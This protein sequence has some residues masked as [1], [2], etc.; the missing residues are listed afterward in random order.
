M[1][2]AVCFSGP[3]GENYP[4]RVDLF[5]FDLPPDKIALRPAVPR[6]SARLLHVQ[7]NGALE[8]RQMTDL[9]SL[10]KPGD[11]LVFNNTKVIPAQLFGVRHRGDSVLRVSATLHQRCGQDRWK[12]FI[13][14]AKRLRQG[15][16]LRFGSNNPA[17]LSGS[18]DGTIAQKGD[19]GEI[20][21][22]FD[23]GGPV[24]DEA[25]TA[26]GHIPLPPYIA[27]KRPDDERDRLDYQTV[28]AEKEGAVAAPTAGLHFTTELLKILELNNINH[29]F[30]TLHVGAGTF[31]PVKADDT[32]E[33]RM[34]A[35]YGEIGHETAALINKTRKSGGRVVAVGTTSLR[36]LE[37]AA[38]EAGRVRAWSGSTD[39]FITPGYRFRLVDG[40]VTNFHLPRS[41]L[42]MLVCAFS[43]IKTMHA[44]YAHA[45]EYGYRF[46]SYGD[47]SLLWRQK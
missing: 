33:H 22:A 19:N 30:I 23:L 38:D 42:F 44:A 18:L 14:P 36:L 7:A 37:S 12:A 4:M 3:I 20:E 24:L 40:L 43:G 10:V 2:G 17:C 34:H 47:G 27:S 28:Y 46:Y 25:I 26:I 11:L 9:P 1:R 41:T 6:D 15:D 31:I 29:C 13:R 35:E 45:V 32:D 21:I 5:D 39:I 8:D 16:R